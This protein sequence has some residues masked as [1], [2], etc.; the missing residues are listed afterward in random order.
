MR[1]DMKQ[2]W[3]DPALKWRERAKWY[4]AAAFGAGAV[5]VVELIVILLMKG[6][7]Q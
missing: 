6:C 7:G 5:A 3:R 4:R 1:S 2:I